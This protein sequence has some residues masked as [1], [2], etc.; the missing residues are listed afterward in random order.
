MDLETLLGSYAF[1]IA[2][3]VYLLWE[4]VGVIRDLRAAIENNTTATQ[5]L[6]ITMRERR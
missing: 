5:E 3:T 4:R 2:V 6:V 1:P